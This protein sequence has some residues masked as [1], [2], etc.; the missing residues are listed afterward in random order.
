MSD[1]ANSRLYG[2]STMSKQSFDT[3]FNSLY[4][5][6]TMICAFIMCIPPYAFS[7][8]TQIPKDVINIHEH[9]NQM[10]YKL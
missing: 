10:T 5:S 7:I 1:K 4:L 6:V 8:F 2:Y 9:K 3:N